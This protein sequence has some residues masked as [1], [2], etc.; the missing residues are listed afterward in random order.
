MTNID[1]IL[2][3][4]LLIALGTAAI[5]IV[6]CMRMHSEVDKCS[7]ETQTLNQVYEN[8]R[9]AYNDLL[10]ALDSTNDMVDKV[11]EHDRQVIDDNTR[12]LADMAKLQATTEALHDDIRHRV[13]SE[14]ERSD[15]EPSS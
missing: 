12:M 3:V 7:F 5:S 8:H 2:A 10:K 9:E 6:V 4:G 14:V 15:S 13:S 1:I 11:L